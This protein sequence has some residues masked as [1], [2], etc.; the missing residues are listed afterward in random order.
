MRLRCQ[1]AAHRDVIR[2]RQHVKQPLRG[3][4]DLAFGDLERRRVLVGI[5]QEPIRAGVRA[6][7]ELRECARY[8]AGDVLPAA[9]DHG[10]DRLRRH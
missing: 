3:M 9:D 10:A 7:L 1:R 6:R 5:E 2:L 4:H 8:R